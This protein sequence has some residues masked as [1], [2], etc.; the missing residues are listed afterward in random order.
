PSPSMLVTSESKWTSIGLFMTASTFF[1]MARNSPRRCTRI[2]FFAAAKISR[3]ISR[4]LSPPP[5]TITRLSLNSWLNLRIYSTPL[6]SNSVQPG[7]SSRF[8]LQDQ[9]GELPGAGV[10]PGREP[11]GPA[12][13]DDQI[14][15]HGRERQSHPLFK[16]SH[17]G[18]VH[19]TEAHGFFMMIRIVM[20]GPAD[21][22]TNTAIPLNSW[23]W[24]QDSAEG[25]WHG[26]HQKTCSSTARGRS[27]GSG[28]VHRLGRAEL[29]E[30]GR[31]SCR[32]RV[33]VW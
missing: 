6:P 10:H 20:R 27:L 30:I 4:A 3:A 12:S 29:R 22:R 15:D 13:D 1:S 2:T 14:V 17:M 11:G 25:M 23:C 31:A 26:I 24:L 32:E 18:T 19:G 16:H 9:G 8:G 5:T 7:S 21:L 28:Y 33:R